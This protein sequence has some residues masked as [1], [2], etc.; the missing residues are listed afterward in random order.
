MTI[1]LEEINKLAD[2]SKLDLT[3]E[4][5]QKYLNDINGIL[6]HLNEI[7]SANLDE[8]TAQFPFFNHTRNDVL[9]ESTDE[10]REAIYKNFPNKSSDNQVKVNK[11][12]KK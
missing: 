3:E 6:D 8:V 9:G 4:E 5:K 7:K 10:T 11:V 1:T 12:L 2:L